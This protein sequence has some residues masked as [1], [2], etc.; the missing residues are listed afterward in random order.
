[1]DRIYRFSFYTLPLI[2]PL[3]HT[4]MTAWGLSII[5][6]PIKFRNYENEQGNKVS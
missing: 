5:N 3:T 4:L 1:M 2:A 6:N